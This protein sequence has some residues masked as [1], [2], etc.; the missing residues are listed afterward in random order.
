MSTA[1]RAQCED[2]CSSRG[3]RAWEALGDSVSSKI[4]KI[5]R[6]FE[7]RTNVDVLWV[8]FSNCAYIF[9]DPSFFEKIVDDYEQPGDVLLESRHQYKDKFVIYGYRDGHTYFYAYMLHGDFLYFISLESRTLTLDKKVEDVFTEDIDD[10]IYSVFMIN[11]E[12]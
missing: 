2:E 6:D 7:D 1:G 5:C 4:P 11:A 9:K 12:K 8:R 3:P 10:F